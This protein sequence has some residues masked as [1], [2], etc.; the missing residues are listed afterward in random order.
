ML[1]LLL[2]I[3]FVAHFKRTSNWGFDE[4]HLVQSLYKVIYEESV[5]CSKS[6]SPSYHIHAWSC[7][8]D[9]LYY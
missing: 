9:V 4:K 8:D 2:L 1:F 5:F 6:E 7:F 3:S